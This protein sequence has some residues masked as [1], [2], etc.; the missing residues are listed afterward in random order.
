VPIKELCPFSALRVRAAWQ[1]RPHVG[2]A[3]IGEAV[4]LHQRCSRDHADQATAGIR[5]CLL[6]VC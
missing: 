3:C 6:Q 2:E 5:G 4:H 1:G